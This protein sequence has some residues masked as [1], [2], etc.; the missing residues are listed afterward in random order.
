MACSVSDIKVVFKVACA[1][2][3]LHRSLSLVVH[4]VS[5]LQNKFLL[6]YKHVKQVQVLDSIKKKFIVKCV[7]THNK[8]V[9]KLKHNLVFVKV[10]KKFVNDRN[11]IKLHLLAGFL[12]LN[13]KFDN[14][15]KNVHN[16]KQNEEQGS[17]EEQVIDKSET[18]QRREEV[19]RREA[20]RQQLSQGAPLQATTLVAEQSGVNDLRQES[21]ERQYDY[22]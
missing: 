8:F 21:R 1:N 20:G 19:V 13:I 2:I 18:S 11:K 4:F 9:T 22:W 12:K 14:T 3:S 15:S 5:S 6:V 7:I 10:S 17:Q 16:I